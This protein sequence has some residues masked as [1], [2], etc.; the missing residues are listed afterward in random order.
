M[1]VPFADFGFAFVFLCDDHFVAVGAE[2]DH[3]V[4][5]EEGVGFFLEFNDLF[6]GLRFFCLADVDGL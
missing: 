2:V 1:D 4:F 5:G 3:A 6:F